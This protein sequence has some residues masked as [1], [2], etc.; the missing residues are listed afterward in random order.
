MLSRDIHYGKPNVEMALDNLLDFIHFAKRQNAKII[1]V[2]VGYGSS[3]K[4]HKIKTA[5]LLFL[6]EKKKMGL[7]KDFILGNDLSIFS[8]KYQSF[9]YKEMIPEE[10]KRK[11]NP[12]VIFIV[13]KK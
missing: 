4:T 12:G 3:G 13:L 5:S 9:E 2:V 6:E 11:L 1:E 7:I 10:E 8:S